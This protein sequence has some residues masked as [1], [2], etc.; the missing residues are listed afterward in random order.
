MEKQH[1][2]ALKSGGKH[3]QAQLSIT[4]LALPL[5]HLDHNSIGTPEGLE[6]LS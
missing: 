4:S 5:D 1:A 6:S 3:V 2:K